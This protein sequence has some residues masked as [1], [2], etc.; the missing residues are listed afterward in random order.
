MEKELFTIHPL[1]GFGLLQFR[2]S[3]ASAK[4]FASIYGEIMAGGYAFNPLET[5]I[6]K[7]IP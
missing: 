5:P 3:V 1:E 2:Q 6:Y 7:V 4:S